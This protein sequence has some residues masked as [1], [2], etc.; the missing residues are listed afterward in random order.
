MGDAADM[1]LD[2][3]VDMFG[4]YPGWYDEPRRLKFKLKRLK[5][6]GVRNNDVRMIRAIHGVYNYL[7]YRAN[8]NGWRAD[9][10]VEQYA[11][12]SCIQFKTIGELCLKIQSNFQRF[13]KYIVYVKRGRIKIHS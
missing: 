8:L 10:M 7:N 11:Y 13:R 1:I 6:L 4:E 12:E 5:Q 9:K 2:G 3:F